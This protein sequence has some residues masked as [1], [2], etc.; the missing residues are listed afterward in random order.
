MAAEPGSVPPIA[1]LRGRAPTSVRCA[2][3]AMLQRLRMERGMTAAQAAAHLG[4]SS[5]KI[6]RMETSKVT[7]LDAS[8]IDHRLKPE[9][10]T[11]LFRLYGVTDEG[12]LADIAGLVERS[13]ERNWW[14]LSSTDA[15]S[16]WTTMFYVLESIAISSWNYEPHFVPGLLQTEDY[17]RA[18]IQVG[19]PR[20]TRQE[21]EQRV[22]FRMKRQEL[23]TRAQAPLDLWALM[24]E[25]V[26]WLNIGN[27]GV[28]ARQLE[29]LEKLVLQQV[30]IALVPFAAGASGCGGSPVTLLQ[31]PSQEDQPDIVYKEMDD[32]GIYSEK[33]EQTYYYRTLLGS[34]GAQAVTGMGAAE[35]IRKAARWHM[36]QT[37]AE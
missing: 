5:S 21:V 32:G 34:I 15:I 20:A 22:A 35:M 36:A 13:N 14:H 9:D 8:R 37:D 4:C 16:G 19:M 3:G 2:L 26:L 6:S 18:V 7:R 27:R 12:Y 25:T 1:G 11:S 33:Q 29:H 23:L 28:M 10:V 17:A 24:S 31:F 30:P